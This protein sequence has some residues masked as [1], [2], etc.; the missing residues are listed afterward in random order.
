MEDNTW[1]NTA[2]WALQIMLGLLFLW[3]GTAK[4]VGTEASVEVFSELGAGQWLRYIIGLLEIAGAILVFVPTT[5]L[6]GG[7]LLAGIMIGAII[8]ELTVLGGTVSTP[9][10]LCILAVTVAW[11]RR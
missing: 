11:L 2:G 8:A 5:A 4:F 7:L 1:K 3:T 10:I 6:L 9:I